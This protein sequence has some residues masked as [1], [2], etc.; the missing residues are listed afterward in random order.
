MEP[1]VASIDV[2]RPTEE[3]FAFATD[4]S[5]FHEW[6]KGVIAGHLDQPDEPSVG[7]RCVTTRRI[8]FADRP[9]T[10]E[11][12]NLD[13]PRTWGVKGVDG[14]IRAR[15]DVLV[16]PL[17][18]GRSRLTISIDFEGHGFGRILLPLVVAAEARKEMPEN[19]AQLRRQLERPT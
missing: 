5:R 14:P 18:E 4:P 16:E 7:A 1:V 2:D 12:T 10:S 19:L 8:G 11:I 13:P 9:V 17:A 15:V 6:Q 3:V